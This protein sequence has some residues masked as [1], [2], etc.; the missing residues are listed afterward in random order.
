MRLTY[1]E[2]TEGDS[3]NK[4]ADADGAGHVA[5]SKSLDYLRYLMRITESGMSWVEDSRQRCKQETALFG[6][7]AVRL[8]AS[9]SEG[10][11][12]S[13]QWG[14]FTCAFY[15][16]ISAYILTDENLV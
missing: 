11:R 2:K 15:S 4:L 8:R 7:V 6:D 10:P 1:S 12:S 16:K 3:A 13:S 9:Q 5:E 14:Q